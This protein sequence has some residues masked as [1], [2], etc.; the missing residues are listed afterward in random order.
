MKLI[1]ISI[2]QPTAQEQ[3]SEIRTQLIDSINSKSIKLEEIRKELKATSAMGE[4]IK[5]ISLL[6]V[7]SIDEFRIAQDLSI[8]YADG[9][10]R[11]E[12]NFRIATILTDSIAKDKAKLMELI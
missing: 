7:G 8:K 2:Q 5:E 3:L 6:K 12:S 4:V 1:A 10:I 11:Y 9:I